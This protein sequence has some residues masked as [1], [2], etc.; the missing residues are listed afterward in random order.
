[1]S[2]EELSACSARAKQLRDK[3]HLEEQK[4]RKFKKASAPQTAP[5]AV[6]TMKSATAGS[7]MMK[8]KARVCADK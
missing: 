7:E 3:R 5:P 8:K 6:G 2:F 4:K 1:M